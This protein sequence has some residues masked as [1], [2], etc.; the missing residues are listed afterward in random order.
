MKPYIHNIT[1]KETEIDSLNHVNNVVYLQ[2]INDVSALHW[3]TLST[4]E[5]NSKYIWVAVRHEID[6]IVAP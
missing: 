3:K 4:D 1:V 2:W 5:I 6:Y